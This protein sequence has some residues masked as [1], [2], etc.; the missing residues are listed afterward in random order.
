M[1]VGFKF[2]LSLLLTATPQKTF[3]VTPVLNS[4]NFLRCKAERIKKATATTNDQERL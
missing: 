2:I 3:L 4:H 1:T